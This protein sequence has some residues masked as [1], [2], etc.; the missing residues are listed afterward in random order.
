MILTYKYRIKDR[1]ARKRL[2]QHAV[3]LNQVWNYACAF[4][5][6]IESR[7]KAGAPKRKWPSEFDLNKLTAGTSRELATHAGSIHEVC[8]V[9]AQSRDKAKHAPRFRAS[10][11]PK[12]ALGWVPFR[13]SDRQI[14]GNAI[15]YLGK[16]FRFFGADR[17]PVPE[18]AKGGSFNEDA[19]GRWW[20]N[21]VVEVA[22]DLPHGDGEIGI[23]LGLK[24]LATCSDGRKIKALRHYRAH[25]RKL[26]AAQRARNK[27][28]GQSD[29]CQDCQL[30]QGSA[31][32][33]LDRLGAGQLPHRGRECFGIALSPRRR[34]RSRCW[35]PVGRHFVPCSRYKAIRHGVEY[36]EIDEKFT[37]QT[38]SACGSMP[39]SRPKGI[40]GLR[41]REWSCSDCGAVHDRDVNAAINILARSAPRLAG[42][43]R[44][45]PGGSCVR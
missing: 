29:P 13:A 43:S 19:R 25:E 36:V 33:S 2:S 6:D 15:T 40:T 23:D 20:L 27:K 22:D 16:Q 30:P 10:F 3:S 38:C 18:T 44:S 8:R 12:R 4:Q 39:A 7:Y 14:V 9:F 35:M 41:I 17:R 1:S 34:W 32:Q 24:T 11:G 42:E 28:P 45:Q 5:R 26:A 37:S 21:I 31:S